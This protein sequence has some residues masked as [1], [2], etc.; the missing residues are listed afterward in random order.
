MELF[1]ILFYKAT[2]YLQAYRGVILTTILLAP[3]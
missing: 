2:G 1:F 3:Q